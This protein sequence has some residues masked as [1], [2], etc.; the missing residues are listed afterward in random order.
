MYP[1]WPTFIDAFP[2]VRPTFACSELAAGNARNLVSLAKP[3]VLVA[4]LTPHGSLSG[5][6]LSSDRVSSEATSQRRTGCLEQPVALLLY[7]R[8]A[9]Y[10]RELCSAP[11]PGGPHTAVEPGDEHR[12]DL[13]LMLFFPP[14]Q[15]TAL[16]NRGGSIHMFHL[17]G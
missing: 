2:D 12:A 6:A 4:C 1:R 11:P 14:S 9:H 16:A 15:K 17:Q 13:G 8:G 7:R 10:H 3:D 5:T